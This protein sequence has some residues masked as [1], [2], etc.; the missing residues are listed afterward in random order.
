M[1][2]SETNFQK[3]FGLFLKKNFHLFLIGLSKFNIIR[4]DVPLNSIWKFNPKLVKTIFFAPERFLKIAELCLNKIINLI[5]KK[6][7]EVKKNSKFY[8]INLIGPFGDKFSSILSLKASCIGELIC[9]RGF[10]I[11]CG[12]IKIKRH[13]SVF[14]CSKNSKLYIKNEKNS[15]V[16]SDLVSAENLKHL[17]MEIEHGLSNYYEQQKIIIHQNQIIN[18]SNDFQKNL[19]VY[20]EKDMVDN[21]YIGEELE[22]CGIFKP[23]K[24]K[25]LSDDLGLFETHLSAISVKRADYDKINNTCKLDFLL[26]SYFSLFSDC[27]DRLSS[28][29]V[30]HI[31]GI[32]FIKKSFLL[33][34]MFSR[35]TNNRSSQNIAENINLLLIGDYTLLKHEIFSFISKIFDVSYINNYENFLGTTKNKVE[36]FQKKSNIFNLSK[37]REVISRGEFHYFDNLESLSYKNKINMG[38]IL[39]KGF[40]LVDVVYESPHQKFHPTI[41]GWAKMKNNKFD[42]R[43]SI[44]DNIDFPDILFGQ[45]DI[46]LL[47]PDMMIASKE[48]DEATL[49]L[50]NH[51]FS[52]S[53]ILSENF[54]DYFFDFPEKVKY[55]LKKKKKKKKINF[56]LIS[57]NFLNN[58]IYYAKSQVNCHLSDEA[59]T[60]LS[61]N[62]YSLKNDS[63][64]NKKNNVRIIETTVRLSL[65]LARCHLREFVMIKDVEYI[66]EFLSS[67]YN[68]KYQ[69]KVNRNENNKTFKTK[70][71]K[72]KKFI[73]FSTA[74]N[75]ESIK[76]NWSSNE[77]GKFEINNIKTLKINK[78]NI[79]ITS[80]F[81]KAKLKGNLMTSLI[82]RALSEWN[83][84]NICILIGNDLIKIN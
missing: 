77:L 76:S 52:K 3:E 4:I 48:K 23:L 47:L 21:F 9:I 50:N 66:N 5:P 40:E 2:Y 60:F 29:I 27:F 33:S 11:F 24:L 79:H 61:N 67:I 19:L 14:F 84:K 46:P 71:E 53:S 72:K 81:I 82:E 39:D 20:L 8:K 83:S 1:T 55:D 36:A 17:G 74:K 49:T 68:V 25:N 45:F 54:E 62:Y 42:F 38:K 7:K 12:K 16:D 43:N 34:L 64:T 56:Q 15:F 69:M 80:F 57:N 35:N 70:L 78:K 75:R 26:C 6:K 44:Q 22:L 28:L 32:E 37:K 51:L 41:F 10:V 63:Q 65:A 31:Q 58:Y 30:P 13:H 59:V 18:N 73:F